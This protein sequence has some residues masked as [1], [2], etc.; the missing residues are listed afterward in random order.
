[1]DSCFRFLLSVDKKD[2]VLKPYHTLLNLS[3]DLFTP[4][5]NLTACPPASRPY[6]Q[7]LFT[8]LTSTPDIDRQQRKH[9]KYKYHDLHKSLNQIAMQILLKNRPRHQFTKY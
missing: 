3:S 9:I 4:Y 1:M 6:L 2:K 5:N 7:V 8:S